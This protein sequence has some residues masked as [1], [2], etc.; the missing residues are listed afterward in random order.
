MTLWDELNEEIKGEFRDKIGSSVPEN[1]DVEIFQKHLDD[2]KS[3]IEENEAE[4]RKNMM[5]IPGILSIFCIGL[6]KL[7]KSGGIDF[8]K[9]EP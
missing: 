8:E 3:L 7:Y 5:A 4:L 9:V 2:F 6:E 1:I